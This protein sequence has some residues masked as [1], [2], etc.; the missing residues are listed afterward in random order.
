MGLT[1]SQHH[2]TVTT[3]ILE[4]S[5]DEVRVPESAAPWAKEFFFGRPKWRG[6]RGE[7]A[8]EKRR[9]DDSADPQQPNRIEERERGEGGAVTALR[10]RAGSK[11]GRGRRRRVET[12]RRRERRAGR[13]PSISRKKIA[14]DTQEE[15]CAS[16]SSVFTRDHGRG[17]SG[18]HVG[19]VCVVAATSE[20]IAIQFHSKLTSLQSKSI[21]QSSPL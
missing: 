5:Q 18:C 8:E 11:S 7:M 17:S 13:L 10:E 14:I 15:D 9:R 2:L 4:S 19:L 1:S 6:K 12:G 3:L 20:S 21:L 16:S